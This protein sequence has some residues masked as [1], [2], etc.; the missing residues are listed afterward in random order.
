MSHVATVE[1]VIKN[2]NALK[3]ACADCGLEFMEGQTTYKWFG[4]WV[5]DYSG[6]NAAFK[7]GIKPED[8]GKCTHA[9]RVKGNSQAYEI[10][11]INKQDGS[12]GLVWDFWSG[13][14]GLEKVAGPNCGNLTMHYAKHV[15]TEKL[16]NQGYMVKQRITD[17]GE[18][19]LEAVKY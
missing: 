12:F 7:H 15:A 8:Y 3:K 10:G 2:L 18:I 5:N 16:R 4:K 14:Y 19:E 17:E 9:I 6:S 1:L 13:G 11:V